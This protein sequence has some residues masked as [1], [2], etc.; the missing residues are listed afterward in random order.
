MVGIEN[1]FAFIREGKYGMR[2]LACAYDHEAIV[3]PIVYDIHQRLAAKAVGKGRDIIRRSSASRGGDTLEKRSHFVGVNSGYGDWLPVY[4]QV[5]LDCELAFAFSAKI[6]L[7][8]GRT[9]LR[10]Y[11]SQRQ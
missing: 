10:D 2:V 3:V 6:F 9:R 4:I 8:F 11:K 7:V 5:I 1:E